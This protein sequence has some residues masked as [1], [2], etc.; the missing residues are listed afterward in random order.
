[1]TDKALESESMDQTFDNYVATL[2]EPSF[3]AVP[4]YFSDGD[5]VSYF[6]KDE[7]YY[8]QRIDSF[9]T[10]YR[11]EDTDEM[12]GCKIKSVTC[13][14]K[15]M[16]DFAVA[17]TDHE[18][19]ICLGLLFLTAA[20][21]SELRDKYDDAAKTLGKAEIDRKDLPSPSLAA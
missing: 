20:T 10:V 1:M 13:L 6:I 3:V 21:F 17:V 19:K 12:I 7:M 11:S 14:M 18:S 4:H 9:V 15:K 8:A 16:G 2:G 5:F